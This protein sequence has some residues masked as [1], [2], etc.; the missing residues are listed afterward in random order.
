[1]S[2]DSRVSALDPAARNLTNDGNTLVEVTLTAVGAPLESPVAGGNGYAIRRHS[3][4]VAVVTMTPV[5]ATDDGG[6]RLMVSDPLPAGFETPDG[7]K[8]V[9][10]C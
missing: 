3:R 5:G 8:S 4:L 6:G 7:G 1:M 10:S 9:S 2:L